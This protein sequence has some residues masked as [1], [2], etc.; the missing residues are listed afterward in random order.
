MTCNL[1]E[2]VTKIYMYIHKLEQRALISLY[3][4]LKNKN[5]KGKKKERNK[6]RERI[7]IKGKKNEN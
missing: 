1:K 4:E 2:Q 6:M 5:I 7:N 3:I